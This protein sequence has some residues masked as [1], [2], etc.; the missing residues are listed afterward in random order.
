MVGASSAGVFRGGAGEPL[1]LIHVGANPWHKREP[2]LP[3]LTARYD[4]LAPTMPGFAGGAELSGPVTFETFVDGVAAAMD[5]AGLAEAHL[6]GNSLGGWIAFEL[7]RRGRAR[8]V[9]AISPG[10]GWTPRG[11]RRLRRFFVWNKRLTTVSRP[12]VPVV[13]RSALLRRV[14]FRLIVARPERL[15]RA[16]AIALATDTMQGDLRRAAAIFESFVSPYPDFGVPTLLT[17]S[18]LDRFT[19]LHPDG[20]TWRQAAPHAEWRVLPGV[21]HLP[22]FDDPALVADT[23]LAHL[24]GATAAAGS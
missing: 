2:V 12:F 11:A 10:G 7:A 16:Q 3:Q 17:W 19:P 23:M 5:A 13:L 4:V 22:M 8:S 6:A 14:F 20:E 21:G 9:L 24:D 18:E 15:T 1:V